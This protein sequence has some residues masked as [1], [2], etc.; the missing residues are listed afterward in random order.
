MANNDSDPPA[1]GTGPDVAEPPVAEDLVCAFRFDGKG[2]ATPITWDDIR[3]YRPRGETFEWIHIQHPRDPHH[4]WLKPEY[5]IDETVRAAL[6]AEETRPR[7]LYHEDGILLNLRGV[8]LNPGADPDDMVSIR[9]F[10]TDNRIISVRLRRL[11][12]V[13]D[14]RRRIEAGKGPRDPGEFVAQLALGLTERMDPVIQE[15][16]DKIDTVEEEILEA[17][18]LD[19]RKDLSEIRLMAITLRRHIAAQKDAL[20][21][22]VVERLSWIDEHDRSMLR[23]ASDRNIRFVEDLD[24]ARE[25]TTILR[26][27]LADVRAEVMNKNM[28][29]LSI[30]A[31]I[32]LPM[33]LLTGLLGINVAGIPFA[34]ATWAFFGVCASLV[35]IGLLEFYIFKRLGWLD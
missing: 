7:F 35:G 28:F 2:G 23:E 29:V 14:I 11:M 21:H 8:N 3:K 20:D 13:Q 1:S 26:E 32:F 25:R 27:Q 4:H 10:I 19:I 34:E 22:L 16:N 15:L 18:R 5:G 6:L 33:G 12:A 17:P 24:S 31:A 9:M 30:V